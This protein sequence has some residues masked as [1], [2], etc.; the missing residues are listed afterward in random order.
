MWRHHILWH[1][2]YVCANYT[3][4]IACIYL[5]RA[6]SRI[7]FNWNACIIHKHKFAWAR[8]WIHGGN[9][10]F[11]MRCTIHAV[12]R[13]GLSPGYISYMVGIYMYRGIIHL[14]CAINMCMAS[15]YNYNQAGPA[16]WIDTGWIKWD[17]AAC[18][19]YIYLASLLYVYI[20]IY[21]YIYIHIHIASSTRICIVVHVVNNQ[22]IP[23]HAIYVHASA[24]HAWEDFHTYDWS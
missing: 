6:R 2:I 24:W 13:T 8:T 11:S 20:Y 14:V 23:M 16:G 1:D 18:G 17:R 12:Y 15:I 7:K 19:W 9:Y 22:L 10:S 5:A 21:I 4:S 3:L